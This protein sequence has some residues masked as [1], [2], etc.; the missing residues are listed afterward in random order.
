MMP[1]LPRDGE[2]QAQNETSVMMR[3]IEKSSKKNIN[4]ENKRLQHLKFSATTS[5]FCTKKQF[6]DFSQNY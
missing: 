6:T 1:V 2:K 5:Y 3:I 4:I